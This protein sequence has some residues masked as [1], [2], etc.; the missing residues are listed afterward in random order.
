MGLA[1]ETGMLA[2]LLDADP[3][4]AEFVEES[5]NGANEVL[6]EL[7]LP[8]HD[9]PRTSPSET[10]RAG[11]EGFGYSSIHHLRRYYAY[12]TKDPKWT[13]TPFPEDQDPTEDPVVEEISEQLQSHLLCHSDCEGLYLPIDFSEVIIDPTNE[14]RVVGGLLGSSYR[15]MDELI[16]VAPALGI[17]LVDGQLTDEQAEVINEAVEEEGPLERELMVWIALFEAARISIKHKTAIV[18]C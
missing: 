14:D 13:P 12:I 2:D 7:G 1:I 16:R 4:G 10:S 6:K 18:F 9:E 5:L 11:L 15:L 3:E 17:D 8:T